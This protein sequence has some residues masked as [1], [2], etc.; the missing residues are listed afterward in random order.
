MYLPYLLSL[1]LDKGDNGI[2][3]Y[4]TIRYNMTGL[5]TNLLA[6]VI[7]TEL[8]LEVTADFLKFIRPSG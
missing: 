8:H 4:L 2:H 1:C 3:S 6:E 5:L 7:H